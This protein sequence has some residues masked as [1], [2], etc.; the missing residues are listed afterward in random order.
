MEYKTPYETFKYI[1][2]YIYGEE[3]TKKLHLHSLKADE[4]D[5]SYKL[6]FK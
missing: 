3:T 1:Y 5:L 2:I 4:V 6:L